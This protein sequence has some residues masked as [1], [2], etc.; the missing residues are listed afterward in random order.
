MKFKADPIYKPSNFQMDVWQVEKLVELPT[1]E[2]D[3]LVATPLAD[4]SVIA[5][6]KKYMFSG[7]GTLH[8]L[9][10]LGE[11]RRDGVLVMSEK[12]YDYVRCGAYVT[13]ARDIVNA[14]LERA[15]DLII[16][17]CAENPGGGSWQA[18]FNG[19][20]RCGGCTVRFEELESQLD[21]TVRDGNGL[22]AMLMDTLRRR[23]GVSTV[24]LD[25]GCIS[26][27]CDLSPRKD[28]TA[29]P[30]KKRPVTFTTK[31]KADLF[32]NAVSTV[33]EIFDGEDLYGMLH[34]SFGLTLQEIR[35]RGYMTDQEIAATCGV[36]EEMLDCDITVRDVL[37]MDGVSDS[38]RLLCDGSD[39]LV[40]LAGLETLSA[41]GQ[42]ELATLLDAR[43]ADIRL[44]NG[45][46][47]LVLEAAEAAELE[48]LHDVLEAQGQAMGPA[49][50]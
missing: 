2:F 41:N 49:M 22:D 19:R 39:Y 44:D 8:A 33:C 40:P 34:D 35:A 26:A 21:L 23:P 43:V 4:H 32:E 28:S 16:R 13:G 37:K 18:C 27:V 42:E 15:A 12:G 48:R 14:E 50:G 20:T 31:R 47:E 36:P 45:E 10:V 1:P 30:R 17:R 38:V 29:A 5:E 46:S 9:L 11:G 6:N 3:A 7:G 25:D 24:E